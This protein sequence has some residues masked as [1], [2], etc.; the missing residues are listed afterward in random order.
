VYSVHI[1]N[2]T[3]LNSSLIFHPKQLHSNNSDS[4]FISYE[5]TFLIIQLKSIQMLL[6]SDISTVKLIA[7]S[8]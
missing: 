4:E 3:N 1:V 2:S 8:N 6:A 5:M 7:R